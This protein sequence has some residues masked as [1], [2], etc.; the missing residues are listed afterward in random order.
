MKEIYH[1]HYDKAIVRIHIDLY[2]LEETLRWGDYEALDAM[3]FQGVDASITIYRE[4]ADQEVGITGI[5]YYIDD[6]DVAEIDTRFV[7]FKS[8]V[9]QAA[10]DYI[11]TYESE[12]TGSEEVERA[13]S[14]IV[15]SS[16]IRIATCLS[17]K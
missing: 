14:Y 6:I 12:I 8:A 2:E 9:Y 15:D 11:Y 7:L 13:F 17:I 5:N 1:H 10:E 3:G 16:K 4:P